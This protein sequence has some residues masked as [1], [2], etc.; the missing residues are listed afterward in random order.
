MPDPQAR[1]SVW[2]CMCGSG[3]QPRK[4]QAKQII[5]HG[6]AESI[7]S[8]DKISAGEGGVCRASGDESSLNFA[9]ARTL[10]VHTV[11]LLRSAA[12][13]GVKESHSTVHSP[14]FRIKQA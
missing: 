7:N 3:L 6:T 1:P 13:C 4:L 9:P 2:I 5:V 14:A 8:A 12:V 10:P 11:G